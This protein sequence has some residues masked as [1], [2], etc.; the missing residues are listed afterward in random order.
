MNCTPPS[1]KP[2]ERQQPERRQSWMNSGINATISIL[3]IHQIFYFLGTERDQGTVR[4][5]QGEVE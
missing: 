1:P 5:E 4:E 3:I 2:E